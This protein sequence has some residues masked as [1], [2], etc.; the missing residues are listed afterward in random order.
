MNP[1]SLN[2][3][4]DSIRNH[5]DGRPSSMAA[6]VAAM[7]YARLCREVNERL[8]RIGP[9][10]AEGGE[11]QALQIAEQSPRVLD[12]AIALSFGGEVGWQEYCQDRGHEVAPMVDVR[13]LDNL[14]AIEAKGVSSNHPLY[15]DYRS[16]VSCKNDAKAFELIRIINRLNPS[17]ENAAREV[18]RLQRKAML[19]AI[20]ELRLA[21]DNRDDE[22]VLPLM[23]RVEQAGEPESYQSLPEWPRALAVRQQ[24]RL[25]GARRRMPEL[26]LNA[27]RE[28]AAGNWRQAAARMGEYSLLFEV[29]GRIAIA[30]DSLSRAA[31]LEEQLASHRVDTER[32]G[33][34]M[35]WVAEMT[36]IAD[37]VESR[38]ASSQGLTV[39]IAGPMLENLLRTWQLVEE[40]RGVIPAGSRS[41]ID[42]A[43]ARLSETIERDRAARRFRKLVAVAAAIVLL[44]SAAGLGLLSLRA[45]GHAKI[46]VKLQARG[47]TQAV[48][49]LLQQVKGKEAILLRFPS[50][51][52]A[53]ADAT[54]WLETAES[55]SLF[56]GKELGRLEHAAEDN[57]NGVASP[58]LYDRLHTASELI[59][60]LP[61]DLRSSMASRLSA[62][63][64][65]GD[66]VL[67]QRQ[68]TADRQAREVV[69]KSLNVL[70]NLNSK[71]TARTNDELIK[72]SEGAIALFLEIARNKPAILRLPNATE[73]QI[74]NLSDQLNKVRKQIAAVDH[75]IADLGKSETPEAYRETLKLLAMSS[76][77]EG[78]SARALLDGWKDDEQLKAF[79][80]FR[81][82]MAALKAA[83]N[84][85]SSFFPLPESAV[86]ID[87]EI[88]SGLMNHE[89]LNSLWE[90]TWKKTESPT[91]K[92]ISQKELT[93]NG[94]YSWS[95]RVAPYPS[96][97][98]SGL[99]FT[100]RQFYCA[101]GVIE[102]HLSPVS[103]MMEKLQL[104]TVLDK[105]GQKYGSSILPLIDRVSNSKEASPLA[106]GYILSKLYK[107][108]RGRE[109]EWGVQYCP[110]LINDIEAF[111]AN[112][113]KYPLIDNSWLPQEKPSYYRPWADYFV[114]KENRSF[115]DNLR[116]MKSAAKTGLNSPW[117]LAGRVNE[118]GQLKLLPFHGSRLLI[119]IHETKSGT[120]GPC[121][122]GVATA[123]SKDFISETPLLP[124]S[125]ILSIDIPETD[126]QFLQSIHATAANATTK[127]SNP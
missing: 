103:A 54:R 56:S 82:D 95:G 96:Y 77:K 50:L 119:G 71:G 20:A 99:K 92:L 100:D 89:T 90:I 93:R 106:R 53:D 25:D 94:Q 75:A 121:L 23:A 117:V 69:T 27:E 43:R 84:D 44:V 107:L 19:A 28:M 67:Q 4:I 104:T 61:E 31:K 124:L 14:Q 52:V 37:D 126:Q 125:P 116:K 32:L 120:P 13:T 73:T 66:R 87:R 33:R 127:T 79:L 86:K 105:T 3:L 38:A 16:A 97:P 91:Q 110:D 35:Q 58:E 40:A 36:R 74:Q 122:A 48:S 83:Y 41:R 6:E 57:F 64:N 112:E 108:I 21:L 65:T 18:K 115:F 72:E 76:F 114:G 15:K 101:D 51:A 11:I 62:V 59:E 113:I 102:Q 55:N 34:V 22:A 42:S 49:Q 7:E 118:S 123:D 2:D 47:S 111:N 70:S 45:T 30:A 68:E 1:A 8:G 26:L 17:D 10:L 9:M 63:N 29:Y 81:N 24:L 109:L 12:L 5:L 39:E 80:I 78:E 98:S 60:T 46:L 88:I 85:T